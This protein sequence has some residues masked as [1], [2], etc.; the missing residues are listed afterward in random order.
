[1]PL[2]A[3]IVDDHRL[4]AQSIALALRQEGIDCSVA[5]LS[6]PQRL[7]DDLAADP[8]DVV[9]LDL[10]LGPPIGDGTELSAR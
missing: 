5:D 4:L 6:D 8:P 10:D 1:M 3:V 2:R 7:L 9:L